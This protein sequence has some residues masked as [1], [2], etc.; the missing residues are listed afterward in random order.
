MQNLPL[1]FAPAARVVGRVERA[2]I[3]DDLRLA[4]VVVETDEHG[5]GLVMAQDLTITLESV[6]IHDLNSIKSY[7]HGEELSIYQ[8][9]LGDSI[10]DAEGKELGVVS[11][12]LL[13]DDQQ[14]REIEVSAGILSDILQGRRQIPVDQVNWKSINGGLIEEQGGN[15]Q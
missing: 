14:V 3:G 11:D 12:F 4:Y 2:V 6:I 1:F 13:S 5:P 8:R 10:F 7:Q 9:K 15:M